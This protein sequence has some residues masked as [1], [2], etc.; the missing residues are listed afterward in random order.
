METVRRR[1]DPARS[2]EVMAALA[3][4]LGG[5]TG[6]AVAFGPLYA[7]AGMLAL[8]AGYALLVSTSAGLLSVFAISTILPFATL[9][10]KAIITPNFLTLA[11]VALLGVWVLRMLARPAEF[12]LRLSSLGLPILAFT[13]LTFFSLYL[14]ARGLPDPA[15]LHNYAKY[16]LGVLL[17]FSVINCVRTH[18]EARLILRGLILSGA[19]AALI[20]L[21]LWALNADVTLRIL[22]SLGPLGYPTSG[23][24]LRFV[25]DD[26]GG[27]ER[28]IGFAV[29][30]NSFGGMLA[31]VLALAAAQLVARQPVMRRWLLGAL[32]AVML[33]TL[34]LTFSRAALLGLI[35]AAAYLATLR[36]RRLWWIMIAAALLGTGL[37]F[38]LGY[39][40]AFIERLISGLQFRDQAQQMRLA[41]FRNAIAIIQR[42]PVFGIGFGQAPDLDLTAGVSSIYLAIAQRMGLVGLLTFLGIVGAWFAR[43]IAGL[44][45][46]DDERITWLLGCQAG[47]VA[48]LAV[49]LADHY[50]FNIEF[51][52]MSAL[53]W[54]TL[55]LGM[56]IIALPAPE[57]Q[58]TTGLAR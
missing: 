12:E 56:A 44:A 14:G 8:L 1:L 52:H 15:T 33:L 17:Y 24:V 49:G 25:E 54:G 18:V 26:P 23:R 53:L 50:F 4:T 16:V 40:G 30:P 36:Y 21:V 29:D 32:V 43:T 11:L 42:Y 7:L 31:L 39:A 5:I 37:L 51:S 10:F 9:P 28:A 46:L 35:V 6:G 45:A 27:L 3:L 57:G 2:P 19:G 55:G 58:G 20:G 22:R 34:L 13:G 38:G 47:V 41:E 48:A